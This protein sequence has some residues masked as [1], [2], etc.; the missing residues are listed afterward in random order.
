MNTRDPRAALADQLDQPTA[1]ALKLGY[2]M[3]AQWEPI[4]R[5]WVSTPENTET[6]PKCLEQA[7]QQFAHWLD[8]LRP[9]VQPCTTQSLAIPTDDAWVRDYGPIFVVGPKAQLACHDFHFD[10]W[11]G[12]Y[13]PYPN[14]NNAALHIA[15]HLAIPTWIHDTVLEGGSI[16][17][18][19]IGSVLTTKQCL[20]HPTRNPGMTTQQ[21][22]QQLHDALGTRHVIWLPGGIAGDDTDGHVDTVARFINTNTVAA[23]RTDPHSPDHEIL[24]QN[25]QTLQNARDQD[26]NKLNL[27][28]LPAPKPIHY[29]FPASDD[30]PGGH[31]QLPASYANFLMANN[32][33]FVPTFG[34]PQDDLALKALETA[35]PHMTVIAVPS[36]WLIV[37]LGAIH[38]LCQPQPDP[39]PD[40]AH[41][42]TPPSNP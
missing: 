34:C 40:L 29:N 6:W 24:Q 17:V 31:K 37:G 3:P 27:V 19:G 5:L 11:G 18:N 23:V 14:D 42:A 20:L 39:A 1:T 10:G 33:L 25:W 9:Y 4:K 15:N 38:C 7:Q 41:T 8:L 2:R 16:D 36:R 32:A 26:A 21:V 35:L 13:G 12:K 22:E 30:D 28:P